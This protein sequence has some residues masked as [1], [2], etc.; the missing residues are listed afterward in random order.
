MLEPV[1]DTILFR[2]MVEGSR[3]PNAVEHPQPLWR[4]RTLR[5]SDPAGFVQGQLLQ[6]STMAATPLTTAS[7]ESPQIQLV[8]SG[9]VLGI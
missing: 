2:T 5:L 1:I 7:V 4:A 3:I 6:K 9:D 8:K